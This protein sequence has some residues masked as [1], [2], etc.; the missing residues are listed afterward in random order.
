LRVC[1]L[2]VFFV[3]FSRK[4][5]RKSF[6]VAKRIRVLQGV[7]WEPVVG[8]PPFARS[9]ALGLRPASVQFSVAVG[10]SLPP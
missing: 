7:L 4:R 1:G 5:N 9:H 6:S 8:R 10:K 3:P 2:F